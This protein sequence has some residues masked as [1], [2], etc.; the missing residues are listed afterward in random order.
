MVPESTTALPADTDADTVVVGVLAG[1]AVA[2]DVD[3]GVLQGLVDSGEAKSAHRH[4]A[5]AHAGGKRWILVGLGSRDELDGERMRIAAGCALARARELGARRL[6]W[7]LPH[8]GGPRLAAAVVEGTLLCAYRYV[9]FKAPPQ[10]ERVELDALIV[11]AHDDVAEAVREA[12]IVARAV[13]A[14]RDLQNA[15]PNECAP[16][17]LADAARALAELDGVSVDVEGRSEI[18]GRGMGAFAGVA[19]GS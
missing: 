4:L 7:E 14:T 8:N 11:C 3:G 1:E 16:R 18:E 19:Q 10:E 6:C 17:H 12:S 5:V 2:H 13:N 9:R 15:P